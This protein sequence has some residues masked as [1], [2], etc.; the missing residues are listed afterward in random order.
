MTNA[1]DSPLS[2]ILSTPLTAIH[3]PLPFA[4]WGMDILGPFP[5]ATGQRK[6]LLVAVDY[7]T[8]WVEAEPV[9]SITENEVRKFIW[10]NIVTV[11][12]TH[13]TL[14]TNREV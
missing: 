13:L 10:K 3:S 6:F 4:T 8:K 12:Y 2:T 11:S 7:F 5:K 9:A 1:S 14:P